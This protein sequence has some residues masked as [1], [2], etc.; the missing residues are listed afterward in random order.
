MPRV[1]VEV[2]GDD[3]GRWRAALEAALP[4]ARFAS[5]GEAEVDYVVAWKPR[6]DVLARTV[7]RKAIFNLGA[8]VDYLLAV[9]TLPPNVPVYR[10]HD[11]GM[12]AQ[13]AD[14]AVA[15]VLRAWR[16]LDAYAA[17][18]REG[19]WQPRPLRDR[20]T[21]GVGVMGAGVLGRAVLAALRPFGF[22]LR[23]YART[24]GAIE[25]VQSFHGEASLP[26]FLSG[27]AVCICLLPATAATR[28]LFDAQRLGWLP[29]GAHLVNLARGELVV[30]D[31]L[32]AALD[33]G[34]LAGATLDV[35][36]TEPLPT[37]HPFWHHPR[38]TIT[39]HVSA[40]TLVSESAAQVAAGI[41]AVEAGHE[42]PGRVDR[43][44]GY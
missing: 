18:Q 41:R 21:F 31:A 17:A 44:R 14:Y 12:A 29:R 27:C 19:R 39:P 20:S 30:D 33:S 2:P 11:A 1:L 6:P 4:D 9:P 40:I 5:A 37:D 36:R 8:G 3:A 15:A 16:E 35:F 32:V 25:G 10:L 34:A 23:G 26:A 7:V 24:A 43:A 28:D 42:P 13:M 22:P 38:V